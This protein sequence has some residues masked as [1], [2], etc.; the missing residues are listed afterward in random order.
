[1]KPF[2]LFGVTLVFKA[3]LRLVTI[4]INLIAPQGH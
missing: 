2:K 4:P 1:M 3:D